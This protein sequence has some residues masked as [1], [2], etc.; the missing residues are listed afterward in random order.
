MNHRTDDD[1]LAGWVRLGMAFG[2]AGPQLVVGVWAVAAPRSWFDSFPGLD[3]RL[4][5]AEPPFNA[6]LATDAGAGFLATAAGLLV[7]AALARRTAAYVALAAYAAFAVPHVLYH[8]VNPAPGLT[9]GE[10]ALN[11]VVLAS[12]VV[13][14]AVLAWGAARPVTR[15][16]PGRRRAASVPT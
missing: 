7:A 3:P 8:A 15:L 2:L 11:V 10:D 4:V 9:G 6:H 16:S 5:A 1:R 12:G 14:A 13:L